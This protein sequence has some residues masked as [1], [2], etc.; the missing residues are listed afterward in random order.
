MHREQR[1]INGA[2]DQIGIGGNQFTPHHHRQQAS[3]QEKDKRRDNVLNAD[4]FVIGAEGEESLP[5][6][7][8]TGVRLSAND[9]DWFKRNVGHEKKAEDRGQKAEGSG[10]KGQ[11]A[12]GRRGSRQ[13]AGCKVKVNEGKSREV[14]ERTKEKSNTGEYLETLN[15]LPFLPSALCLLPSALSTLADYP[16]HA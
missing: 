6:V 3:N 12:E 15:L 7:G 8:R 10:G 11:K 16:V 9:I 13:R 1:I 5:V 4:D 14:R 2:I